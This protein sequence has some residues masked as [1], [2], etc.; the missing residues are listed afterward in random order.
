MKSWTVS[1]GPVAAISID[2]EKAAAIN[3]LLRQPAGILPASPGDAIRPFARGLFEEFRSALKPDVT[4][5][6]LRRAVA[7]FVH[8]KRYYLAS[9]QPDAY[10]HDIDGCPVEPVSTEDRLLAQQRFLGLS[11]KHGNSNLSLET[12]DPGE[13]WP[14]KT[15]QMRASL[16]S[17]KGT[18][19]A[20][21]N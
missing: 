16:L 1:R 3:N 21:F 18:K 2:A 5:T 17:G 11:R 9:A 6:T 19:P 7:T 15:Q 12:T 10:R 20:S 8:S 13:V 4:V 14:D